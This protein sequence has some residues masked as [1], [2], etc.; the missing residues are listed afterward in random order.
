MQF[1]IREKTFEDNKWI[2]PYMRENWGSEK[3]VTRSTLY[4]ATGLPGF[5]AEHNNIPAGIILYNIKDKECEITLLESFIEKMGIGSSLINRVKE[6][7]KS[8]G[9]RRIWL[10]TTNDNTHAIRFY[11]KRGLVLAAL[12]KNA[13]EESRKIKPEI[14]FEGFDGIPIRD[15]IELELVLE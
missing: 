13:I 2:V 12:Y 4:D 14:P 10:I 7:A 15:E 11:Q 6:I 9:C 8:Q 3:I 1:E 5:I